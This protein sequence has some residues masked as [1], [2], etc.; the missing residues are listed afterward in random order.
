M[1][2]AAEILYN[3]YLKSHPIRQLQ[4]MILRLSDKMHMNKYKHK[5]TTPTH[6]EPFISLW[7][8]RKCMF[9]GKISGLD[10]WQ[11]VDMPIDMAEC[12]KS[13]IRIGYW[14]RFIRESTN[15]L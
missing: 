11:I 1:K 15:C 13:I 8:G 3:R 2:N 9:C 7:F 10:D 5:F 12:E 6:P 14:D 4:I